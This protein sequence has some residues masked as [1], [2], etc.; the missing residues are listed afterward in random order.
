MFLL[1]IYSFHLTSN[2]M[3][4][5]TATYLFYSGTVTNIPLLLDLSEVS[6]S[7]R[8]TLLP[9]CI[10]SDIMSCKQARLNPQAFGAHHIE[11]PGLN[12]SLTYTGLVGDSNDTLHYMNDDIDAVINYDKESKGIHGDVS[13]STG[14]FYYLEFCGGKRHTMK[15]MNVARINKKKCILLESRQSLKRSLGSSIDSAFNN[16]TQHSQPLWPE[17]SRS[18]HDA[19]LIELDRFKSIGEGVISVNIY[20]TPQFFASTPDIDGYVKQ[21]IDKTNQGYINSKVSTRVKVFCT[22]MTTFHEENNLKAQIY[23]FA[24]MKKDL[25]NTADAAVLF[26]RDD[27]EACGVVLSYRLNLGQRIAGVTKACAIENQGFAHQLGHFMGLGHDRLNSV[28][29]KDSIYNNGHGHLLDRGKAVGSRG[30]HTIMAYPSSQHQQ[31]CSMFFNKV[32][33]YMF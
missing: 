32:L 2:I 15:R 18:F 21:V 28:V 4:K 26:V 14:E 27:P 7:S 19:N 6:M 17:I 30:F 23:E 22:E 33:C 11:L 25:L 29:G 13:T 9:C 5:I 20:Y 8:S 10:G 24:V 3:H 1:L 16:Q 31:V 12:G